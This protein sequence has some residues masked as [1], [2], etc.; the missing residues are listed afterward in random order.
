MNHFS[1][2]N[3]ISGHVRWLP[4][5]TTTA[6]PTTIGMCIVIFKNGNEIKGKIVVGRD[7]EKKKFHGENGSK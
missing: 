3:Q 4:V 5:D 2:S 1:N 6:T 7:K